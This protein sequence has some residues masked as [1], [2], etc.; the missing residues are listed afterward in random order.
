MVGT[1]IHP[2]MTDVAGELDFSKVFCLMFTEKRMMETKVSF[3]NKLIWAKLS[4]K[5]RLKFVP[6]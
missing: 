2:N 1:S 5:K 6:W 3:T 4:R